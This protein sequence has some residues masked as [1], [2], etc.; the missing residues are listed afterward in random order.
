ML[1][2]KLR[3]FAGSLVATCF[4]LQQ[5]VGRCGNSCMHQW[6]HATMWQQQQQK[7]AACG[8]LQRQIRHPCDAQQVLPTGNNKTT[9]MMMTTN[10]PHHTACWSKWR[11]QRWRQI[12]GVHL[13]Q[14]LNA[15]LH[16][17]LHPT[18]NTTT[19]NDGS[20]MLLRATN[21]FF[22]QLPERHHGWQ[23]ATTAARESST[24]AA[25]HPQST[26]NIEKPLL[27]HWAPL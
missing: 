7:D 20:V 3:V 14:L 8:V 11:L 26:C 25:I 9:M 13:W 27:R 6:R 24:D 2:Q 1:T 5:Q 17:T 16:S 4:S 12:V 10:R 23:L 18:C 21:W 15:F 22:I 19:N